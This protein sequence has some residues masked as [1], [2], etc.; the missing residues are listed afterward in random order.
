M[1]LSGVLSS[2]TRTSLG[3]FEVLCHHSWYIAELGGAKQHQ[4]KQTINFFLHLFQSP[5]LPLRA[6]DIA[7]IFFFC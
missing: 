6:A 5:F 3:K 7:T 2:G 4:S 1:S